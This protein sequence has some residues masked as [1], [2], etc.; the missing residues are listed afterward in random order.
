MEGHVKDQE[1]HLFGEEIESVL[2]HSMRLLDFSPLCGLCVDGEEVRG[3][4]YRTIQRSSPGEALCVSRDRLSFRNKEW[5]LLLGRCLSKAVAECGIPSSSHDKPKLMAA[6]LQRAGEA[7]S[8]P[9]PK[10][11]AFLRMFVQLPSD[12]IGGALNVHAKG[13]NHLLS[14]ANDHSMFYCGLALVFTG[15]EVH[16]EEVCSGERTLLIFDVDWTNASPPPTLGLPSR[17]SELGKILEEWDSNCPVLTLPDDFRG[18]YYSFRSYGL[19]EVARDSPKI[20]RLIECNQF[21]SESSKIRVFWGKLERRIEIPKWRLYP[22]EQSVV[23]SIIVFWTA[24][25]GGPCFDAPSFPIVDSGPYDWLQGVKNEKSVDNRTLR[26]ENFHAIFVVK[27]RTLQE[28]THNCSNPLSKLTQLVLTLGPN[29]PAV[30]SELSILCANRVSMFDFDIFR[31]FQESASALLFAWNSLS[32]RNTEEN[33]IFYVFNALSMGRF[34]SETDEDELELWDKWLQS[35]EGSSHQDVEILDCI[36]EL[37][38][39]SLS[40][41]VRLRVSQIVANKLEYGV[42]G[43]LYRLMKDHPWILMEELLGRHVNYDLKQMVRLLSGCKTNDDPTLA[44]AHKSMK[45]EGLPRVAALWLGDFEKRGETLGAEEI[46]STLEVCYECE[47]DDHF[48]EE[49]A[50]KHIPVLDETEK[51]YLLV[52]AQKELPDIR[53]RQ[54]IIKL[55]VEERVLKLKSIVASEGHLFDGSYPFAVFPNPE[56]QEFLRSKEMAQFSVTLEL[57]GKRLLK[58][59]TWRVPCACRFNSKI[60]NCELDKGFSMTV[61]NEGN[62][63]TL[64]KT[65]DYFQLQQRLMEERKEELAELLLLAGPTKRAFV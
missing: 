26:F 23:S 16:F 13:E 33:I 49:F 36:E 52:W 20:K 64:T 45:E 58:E 46:R 10:G 11:N 25:D 44:I 40:L 35:I 22:D 60:L 62:V 1:D 59:Y 2:F 43:L 27:N 3:V 56:I 30:R 21:L 9:L 15:L 8:L 18:D 55:T 7:V 5:L 29:H 31:L 42:L 63:Y 17:A 61:E 24:M 48:I 12:C 28:C 6:I 51:H 4:D 39:I 37:A 38:Q 50:N 65:S 41:P 14:F 32:F 19:P 53:S 57:D 47:L 34:T 54:M